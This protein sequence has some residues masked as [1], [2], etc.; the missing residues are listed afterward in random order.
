MAPIMIYDQEG[1]PSCRLVREAC[2]ILSLTVNFRPCPKNGVQYMSQLPIG[3][4][5]DDLPMV[6]D[7]NTSIEWTASLERGIQPI[8]LYLFKTYGNGYVPW[9]LS[10]PSFTKVTSTLA[11]A[12]RFGLG[13]TY[14]SANKPLKPLT[15][16]GYET[17]PFCKI[18]TETL[19]AH[20]LEYVMIY[21]P[22][23][24]P[25]RQRM[26]DEYGRF[27]VPLLIDPNTGVEL[28]ESSAICEYLQKQYAVRTTVSYL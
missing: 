15:V 4:K 14:R 5:I 13:S 22:R 16:W 2:S 7:P 18:V 1:S 3:T 6:Y 9:V 10:N 28:W 12:S 24:S 19:C 27:Q 11:M 21:T 23:G 26:V 25:N 20:E 8:L 17:S